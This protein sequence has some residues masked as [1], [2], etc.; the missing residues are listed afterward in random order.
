MY[1]DNLHYSLLS[2]YYSLCYREIH[3]ICLPEDFYT[4]SMLQTRAHNKTTARFLHGIFY[5][6]QAYTQQVKKKGSTFNNTYP[7]SGWINCHLVSCGKRYRTCVCGVSVRT[8]SVPQDSATQ[9]TIFSQLSLQFCILF[10]NSS[11]VFD[12]LCNI[13]Q[14]MHDTVLYAPDIKP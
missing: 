8:N 6:R 10:V 3:T 2:T 7:H 12:M 9:Q 4:Y 11:V 13:R 1:I 5:V 14:Y